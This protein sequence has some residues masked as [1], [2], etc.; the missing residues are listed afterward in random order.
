MLERLAPLLLVGLR[1]MLSGDKGTD[2]GATDIRH[3]AGA[4][5]DGD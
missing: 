1:R 3:V 4:P 5:T 2:F